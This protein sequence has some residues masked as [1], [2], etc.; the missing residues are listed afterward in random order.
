M[1]RLT[2]PSARAALARPAVLATGTSLALAA[3]L[4][5]GLLVANA[6]DA[7]PMT[8]VEATAKPQ[9]AVRPAPPQGWE[10]GAAD[11]VRR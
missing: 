10:T 11:D 5:G 6:T 8:P 3:L 7:G 4:A 1:S 2:F 9:P